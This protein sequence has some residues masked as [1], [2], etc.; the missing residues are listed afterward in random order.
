MNFENNFH[1]HLL[2]QTVNLKYSIFAYSH[3]TCFALGW[4]YLLLRFTLKIN[5]SDENYF[6]FYSLQWSLYNYL[7]WTRLANLDMLLPIYQSK[8]YVK[9]KLIA[10]INSCNFSIITLFKCFEYLMCNKTLI[11][12]L[13]GNKGQ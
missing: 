11:E 13:C 9:L 7:P 2:K 10:R 4:I 12:D 8:Y 5:Q 3:Y 6:V 1:N